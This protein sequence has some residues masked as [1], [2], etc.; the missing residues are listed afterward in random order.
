MDVVIKDNILYQKDLK[1]M[2][3]IKFNLDKSFVWNPKI[4]YFKVQR[5]KF[6]VNCMKLIHN[7]L[8]LVGNQEKLVKIKT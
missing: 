5:Y 1:Y 7:Q 2:D 3:K 8:K 4:I 6:S